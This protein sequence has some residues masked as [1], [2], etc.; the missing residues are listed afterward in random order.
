MVLGSPQAFFPWIALSD[1]VALAI[2]ALETE[3]IVGPLNLSSPG[4]VTQGEF[5]EA[6]AKR[7]GKRVWGNVPNWLIKLA[8]GEFGET[9]TF[10]QKMIPEKALG[11][12]FA[13][14]CGEVGEAVSIER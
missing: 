1:W 6:I 13:F 4:V 9:I 14:G 7:L 2:F 5:T 12:G 10:S 8:A 11:A 3:T